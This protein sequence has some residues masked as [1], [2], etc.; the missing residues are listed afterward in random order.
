VVYGEI[1]SP[2]GISGVGG[3][4]FVWLDVSGLVGVMLRPVLGWGFNSVGRFVV[5]LVAGCVTLVG[6]DGGVIGVC[7][8][9]IYWLVNWLSWL[10]DGWLVLC[11]L[12]VG[13]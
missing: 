1:G 3:H 8:L 11:W 4:V 5:L 6:G 2:G 9:F 12:W 7:R 10:R 13:N